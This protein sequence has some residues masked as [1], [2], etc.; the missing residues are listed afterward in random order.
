MLTASMNR[1]TEHTSERVNRKI[2]AETQHRLEYYRWHPDEIDARLAALDA[3]WDVER[4]LETMSASFSLLG[5]ALG[6]S[7]RNRRWFFVPVAVQ[8]FFLQHAL[9]GWCPPLPVL[10]RLG[11]RTQA[12]IMRERYA[13]SSLRVAPVDAERAA[14]VS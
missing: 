7:K 9:Q 11:F 12:E 3:E 2:Q 13:L 1:V 5:L 6:L 10:R 4:M 14:P 8:T